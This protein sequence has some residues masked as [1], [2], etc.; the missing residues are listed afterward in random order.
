MTLDSFARHG[1]ALLGDASLKGLL[2]LAL[3]GLALLA[4]RR[5]SA[6]ARH[7]ILLL[8]LASFL[9]LP[10]LTLA[11]PGWQVP[12]WP[13]PV[14]VLPSVPAVETPPARDAPVFAPSPPDA[15]A[16]GPVTAPSDSPIPETAPIAR[17]ASRRRSLPPWPTSLF[18]LWFTAA[19]LTLAPTLAGLVAV[20]RLA[21]RCRPVTQGPL[22]AQFAALAGE[23]GVGRRVTLLRGEAADLSVIPMTWEWRRPT[24]LLPAGAGEWPPDRLRVVL[25]HEL[26]HIKRGDWPCQMLAHVVCALYWFH[27]GVWLLARGLRIE[28]ERACDDFVLSAG[29]P[30]DDYARHLLEVIKSMKIT[31]TTLRAVLPMAQPSQLK[32]RL[33]MILRKKQSRRSVTRRLAWG[34]CATTAALLGT[35]AALHPAAN[36]KV[37]PAP[38]LSVDPSAPVPARA[39]RAQAVAR[40]KQIYQFVLIYRRIHAG[41]YPATMTQ[42]G[43]LLGD[44][45]AHPQEYDLADRGADNGRQAA[46]FFTFADAAHPGTPLIRTFMHGKRPDGTRVGA[47]KRAGTRDVVANTDLFVE[48]RKFPGGWRTVGDYLVLW[49]DGQ[50]TR[51]PASKMLSVPLYDPIGGLLP[52][53][54]AP[55]GTRQ[56][57]FPGQAGLPIKAVRKL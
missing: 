25:L 12:L 39:I 6:S 22:A 37:L 24:I 54:V 42:P 20:R 19:L 2:I 48:N 46:S 49:D 5:A 7:L 34:A 57:A 47:A 4:G 14:A 53:G 32:G 56:M 38:L 1:L 35:I 43:D 30:A 21:R 8:A 50:V 11:L 33:I 3:V 10:L 36:A 45:S 52:G 31:N 40:L 23:S 17:K 16:R 28:S 41:A 27:P 13:R 29:V 44:L 55:P 15:N 9:A 26:A 51:V 18:L